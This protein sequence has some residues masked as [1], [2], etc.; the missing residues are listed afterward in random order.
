VLWKRLCKI[1][2]RRHHG[3][4]RLTS[5]EETVELLLL[6]AVAIGSIMASV[7]VP[8][9]WMTLAVVA[10]Y[11]VKSNRIGRQTVKTVRSVRPRDFQRRMDIETADGWKLGAVIDKVC[12]EF[13]DKEAHVELDVIMVKWSL[14]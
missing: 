12:H 4:I 10:V 6:G 13:G 14:A 9:L 3:S 2:T 1:L 11:A 5:R 7:I 8:M